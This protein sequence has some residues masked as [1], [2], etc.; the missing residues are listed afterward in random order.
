M[1]PVNLSLRKQLESWDRKM[2]QMRKELNIAEMHA[3]IDK[4]ADLTDM[5]QRYDEQ[6]N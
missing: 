4:K 6:Q 3:M 5:Y 2:V 1:E